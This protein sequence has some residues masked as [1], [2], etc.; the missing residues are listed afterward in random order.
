V[1]V[2]GEL[3]APAN[4][5]ERV[6]GTHRTWDW[7]S[8]RVSLHT[9]N[10]RKI[11]LTLAEIEW[12]FLCYIKFLLQVNNQFYNLVL[13]R[14]FEWLNNSYQQSIF[15]SSGIWMQQ[16]ISQN[17]HNLLPSWKAV[18]RWLCW[19]PPLFRLLCDHQTYR[20]NYG[21]ACHEKYDS[22][23]LTSSVHTEL[24]YEAL[25]GR[26]NQHINLDTFL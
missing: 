13:L 14:I 8:S 3:H 11:S 2:T 22:V 10:K 15:L 6:A 18:H 21:N 26:G 1:E 25:T 4:L 24:Q 17:A 7:V 9:S 19:N 16:L 20:K 12:W 5:A 23:T